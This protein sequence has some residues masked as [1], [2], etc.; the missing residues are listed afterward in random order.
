MGDLMHALP[1]LTE[2]EQNIKNISFDWVVDKGFSSVPGWHPAV[3]R[4]IETDHRNWRKQFLSSESREA[5][6]LVKKEINAA[7]YDFVVD[8]QNNLKS[9]F[10]S[11]LSKHE[12]AGMDARSSREYPAHWAY[13]KKVTIKKSLHAIERQKKLLASTLDY[14]STPDIDYG[15][16]KVKFIKPALE[17]PDN[18]VV[19]VQNAS[20]LTKQWPVAYWKGL[21]KHLDDQGMNVLLPSGNKDELIRAKDIASVSEKATAL[22]ILPLNEVAYIIDN[23]DYCICSDTG[24]AHLSAVVNTPSLTLYGPTDTKLIGTKGKDQIHIVGD[25]GDINNISVEEVINKLPIG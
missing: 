22:E 16:S 20:W 10:L 9:A 18:Y 3:D 5:L 11:F 17:L 15:I 19:L 25:S 6:N 21:V 13:S 12:V 7:D 23:A 8:M 14:A 1:A 4:I 24:L 2:A